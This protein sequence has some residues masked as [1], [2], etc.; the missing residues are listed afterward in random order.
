MGR[1]ENIRRLRPAVLTAGLLSLASLAAP[2]QVLGQPARLGATFYAKPADGGT[3]RFSSVAFDAANN[4]Y[5]VAWGVGSIGARFVSADGVALGNPLT[6]N[7]G[8]GD[9]V[10]VTCAA[11]VNACLLAWVQEPTYVFGRLVRYNNGAVLPLTAAFVISANGKSKLTSAA[12]AVAFSPVASEFLVAWTE[13]SGTPGGPD[14][15]GMRVRP[16]G[17]LVGTQL[18]L[19]ATGF[20]EGLPTMT[21]NSQTDEY[22]VGYYFETGS[23]A[24]SLGVQRVKPGTGALVGGRSTLFS[25]K[26]DIYPELAYN[27][28]TN[29]FM[30]ISWAATSPWMLHGWLADGNLQPLTA[31]PKSLATQGGGD[32]IGLAYNSVSNTF[33]AVYLSQK[34]AE[35][36][37]VEIA[38]NGTPGKQAQLT[39]SGTTLAT[40]PSVAGSTVLQRWAVAASNGYTK[41]MNQLVGHGVMATGTTTGTGGSCTT[42]S[43]G[44]GWTCVNGS[45]LPP[46]T[47]S[48]CTTVKPGTGWTCVNGNWLPPT[49]TT[50]SGGCK[51]ASPGTGWTCVNGGWL[52]PSGGGS[53]SSCT[54]VKPAADWVCVNGNWLPPSLAPPTSSCT[55]VKP[56]TGWTC[57]NGNWLPPSTT[58]TSSCTSVKPG[59]GWTCV[60]GN[61]LPPTT[62]TSSCTT[63]KPGTGWTCV[64]GNWLPPTTPT[65]SCTTVKPGTGWTCVSGNWLPPGM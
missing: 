40:Q 23:G 65:S 54:T 1:V 56:G 18:A 24:T 39:A 52:P 44:A 20:W 50:T 58:S 17:T 61:W 64:N 46:T 32:G 53:T 29:Q 41:I 49:T 11:A 9:G 22:V 57:V 63:V 2:D 34:N 13:F 19:A 45:W 42:A 5:L 33:L 37:G 48:S 3:R 12:P 47:T 15:R 26:S 30:A 51:T 55:T 10:K 14:V 27:S 6:L 60:N 62:S 36:W 38:A 43:P 31:T 59:T 16:N 28:H 7:T 8:T 25:T 4:A 21:Y 35:I